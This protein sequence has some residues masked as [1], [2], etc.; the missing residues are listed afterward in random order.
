MTEETIVKTLEVGI[1]VLPD[2]KYLS[3]IAVKQLLEQHE[4]EMLNAYKRPLLDLG[5]LYFVTLTAPTVCE[6][7]L[8]SVIKKRIKAFQR[9]KDNMRKN[10]GMKINGMRKIEVTHTKEK[11]HPHFH[12]I[13]EGKDEAELLL[14]LWLA[15]FPSANKHAQN[16]T[17]INTV[18]EKSFI[19]LFKYASKDAVKDKT[20]AHASHIINM[21]L[22]SMR[23]LQSFGKL[24][25]IKEPTE[26]ILEQH[27]AEM[28][29][30]LQKLADELKKNAEICCKL[31]AEDELAVTTYDI[32][33]IA[34]KHIEKI[35]NKR[36]VNSIN[37]DKTNMENSKLKWDGNA[38]L[39]NKVFG[40]GYGTDWEYTS[41]ES[42]DIIVNGK[43]IKVGDEI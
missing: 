32:D 3:S 23:T 29:D 15:Q 39:A 18:N 24:R 10:Y 37:T 21:A 31:N 35:K 14:K 20:S 38:D 43:T 41:R 30:A 12:L 28:V 25:R 33:V 1:V 42:Q 13:M 16:I 17:A 7:E 5:T 36:A 9:I 40:D 8:R 6:R 2:G 34:A 26:E 4:A 11:Y 27:E 22:Y 19:E